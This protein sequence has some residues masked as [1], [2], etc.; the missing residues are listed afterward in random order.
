MQSGCV[1]ELFSHWC[2]TYIAVDF[3]QHVQ[4]YAHEFAHFRNTWITVWPGVAKILNG[5]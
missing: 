1:E 2:C 5:T 3:N 4:N